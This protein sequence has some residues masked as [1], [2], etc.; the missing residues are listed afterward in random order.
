MV[1]CAFTPL[2]RTLISKISGGF[3]VL[4]IN[5]VNHC[6][7]RLSDWGCHVIVEADYS[8]EFNNIQPQDV[9]MTRS[10][11]VTLLQKRRRWCAANTVWSIH[12]NNKNVD[13]AG[14]GTSYRFFH[15]AHTHLKNLMYFSP[16]ADTFTQV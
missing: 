15:L 12:R 8:I 2:L 5:D 16:M 9:T 3:L 6:F 14:T 4:H 13:K 10:E 11:A 1:A 7:P